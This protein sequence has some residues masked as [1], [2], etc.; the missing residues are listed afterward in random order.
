MSITA[1]I[2]AATK[3][4]G[5]FGASLAVIQENIANATT[6]GYARRR[7]ELGSALVLNSN[8]SSGAELTTIRAMRSHLLDFQ[9]FAAVQESARLET[10]SSL[11]D[12][13]H[14]RQFQALWIRC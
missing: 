10:T 6:P 12:R 9:C 1:A 4:L 14:A 5:A 11:F 13:V 2:G 7:P 8:V 3:S